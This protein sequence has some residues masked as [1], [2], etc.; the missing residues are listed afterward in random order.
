MANTLITQR[1]TYDFGLVGQNLYYSVTNDQDVATQIK[2]KFCAEV[3]ISNDLVV[4]YSSPASPDFVGIFKTTPNNMGVGMWD[5]RNITETFVSSDNLGAEGS[6]YK[7]QVSDENYSP[8]LQNIDKFSCSNKMVGKLRIRFYTEFLGADPNY[9]NVVRPSNNT[10]I[11]REFLF[12]NGYVKFTDEI[13][14][15]SLSTNEQ[16]NYLHRLWPWVMQASNLMKYMPKFLTNSPKTNFC[17]MEDYGTLSA[18][19]N[20]KTFTHIQLKYHN[21]DGF[22]IGGDNVYK[23]TTNGAWTT[24]TGRCREMVLHLGCYPANLTNWSANFNAILPQMYGGMISIRGMQTVGGQSSQATEERYIRINCPTLKGYE[25]IRLKW[26]NQF[27]A[28]DY[29]SFNLKSTRKISTDSSTYTQLDGTWN[30]RENRIYGYRGGTKQ[31]R[32]N[33]IEKI[34]MNTDYLPEEY[35]VMFEELKNSPEVY[36]IKGYKPEYRDMALNEYSIPVRLTSSD[37]TYKTKANDKLVQ[38]EFEVEKTETLR[39][40]AI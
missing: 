19:M 39:T 15:G 25:P 35:N 10:V 26:I 20:G 23:T 16:F 3:Y 33:A 36:M 9:P 13:N 28:W 27:G 21:A 34:T 2:V 32:V 38:Y 40:Q 17:N 37:F 1:P 12:I 29:F 18:F 24:F 7:L 6:A 31:F 30:E 8:P 11:S 5:M 14:R 22:T 4:D